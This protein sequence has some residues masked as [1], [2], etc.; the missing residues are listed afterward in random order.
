[1]FYA[2]DPSRD[3]RCRPGFIRPFLLACSTRNP[4]FAGNAVVCLQRLIIGKGLPEDSL[5]DV[6]EALRECST[7]ALDI[8]LKV[9][10][11]LPSLLQNYATSF[12]GPLLIAAFQ[13]CFLL[14][15]NKAA[16]V[17]NTAAATLQQLVSS[18]FE[19]AASAQ[20][21][22]SGAV[23]AAEVSIGNDTVSIQGIVLDAYRILDDLSL[24]TEGHKPKHIQG[25]FI[26]QNFG[27]ELIESC[28]ASHTDFLSAR[29]DQIHTLRIRLMP[30][31]IKLISEKTPFSTTVR[32]MR[33]LRLILTKLLVP[34]A[35]EC[36]VALSLLNHMLDG[37]ASPPW[38]RAMCLE[39]FR[40]LHADPALLRDI[41]AHFD[42]TEEK[43]NIVRDHLSGLVRLA[44]EKPAIIGL[45]SQSSIPLMAMDDS[46]EQAA[47]QAGG[48][49][50]SIGAAVGTIDLN[51]SGISN[52]WSIIKTPCIE[53]LDKS[54]EPALPA[55]YIYYLAL[56]C[57]NMFEE[58]LARFL[59]PF[60]VPVEKKQKRRQTKSDKE[61]TANSTE[62]GIG[63]EEE[64]A[65]L[66]SARSRKIPV[67][68]LSLTNHTEYNQISTSAHMVDQCWP[69]LLAASSTYLNA[70]M[71][72][73]NYHALV[74]S[75]Q[76]FTQVA[77]LVGLSTPRDAFL[78]AFGKHALPTNTL[79]A[80]KS[81][82][83]PKLNGQEVSDTEGVINR[84]QDSGP[85]PGAHSTKQWQ[86]I[87]STMPVLNSRHLLCLRAL[88]NLGIALGPVLDKSWT[89]IFE[90]LQQADLLLSA[91]GSAQRKQRPDW[92]RDS[93]RPTGE[94]PDDAE[95]LGL[96]IAAAET[97]AS[98]LFEASGELGREPFLGF[99]DCLCK[100]LQ[101]H[102]PLDQQQPS[103][104]LS[105]KSGYKKH[106]K[107]RSVSSTSIGSSTNSHEVAFVLDKISDVIRTNVLR[108]AQVETNHS[109][110]DLLVMNLMGVLG[111]SGAPSNIRIAAA[112]TFNEMLVLVAV[113]ETT[114]H[115][116]TLEDI[117]A[118][119]LS[120]L[121]CE[122]NVLNMESVQSS[123]TSQHCEFEIHRLALDA[124]RTILEH[125][126]DTLVQG[127][128]D[129]FSIV[130]STFEKDANAGDDSPACATFRARSISS[131][132]VRSSF[133][134]LQL[135][136]SDFLSS[137]PRSSMPQLL[138]TLYYFSSQES[139]LNISLT[140]ATFFRT[141]SDYL[142]RETEAIALENIS[143][144]DVRRQAFD[145]SS[146][147]SPANSLTPL[148]WL[149]LLSQ[150]ARLT[151]DSRLEVRHSAL[152]TLFRI[153]DANVDRLALRSLPA[154]LE[155]VARPIFIA[156][157]DQYIN[158]KSQTSSVNA[159]SSVET[160]NDTAVIA[161][162]GFSRLF[163]Q[164]FDTFKTYDKMSQMFLD[165]LDHFQVCLQ[166][167]V[168]SISKAVFG[169]ISKMLAEMEDQPRTKSL[170]IGKVWQI[171]TRNNPT[172]YVSTTEK[173][174]NNNDSLLAYMY[175]LGQLLRLS[176]QTLCLEQI[177]TTL[178]QLH[179]SITQATPSLHNTDVNSMTPV[180]KAVLEGLK[181]VP[182][183]VQG[184][185][186]L[187]VDTLNTF[188][189]MAYKQDVHETTPQQS[190]V[191]LS[192]ASM[193]MLQSAVTNLSSVDK[194][195]DTALVT[196]ALSSLCVPLDLKYGWQRDGKDPPP[197]KQATITAVS[198]LQ[199][200]VPIV[201]KPDQTSLPFWATIVRIL[202]GI[203]AANCD[204]CI[205]Q[206]R[207][208]EDEVFD[209]DSCSKVLALI[210]PTLG[211]ADIPDSIRLQFSE[212]LFQN[213]L[214]HEPNPDDLAWPGEDLLDGLK[215]D[216]FGSV[217]AL[218]PS[219]RSKMSYVLL[220][221]LFDLVAVHDGSVERINLAKAAGP[222]LILRIGLTLKTYILDQPLRGR[223][224][225]PR[226]QK[227]EMLYILKKM[228]SLNSVPEAIPAASGLT[229][230]RK[231]HL[232]RLYPLILKVLKVAGRDEAM[233]N[234]A[235]SVLEA[236]GEDFEQ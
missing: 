119:S 64:S 52:R 4:K 32:S 111:S 147:T 16:V 182:L 191:A 93:M 14:Y 206:S 128:D 126:G 40:G 215:R 21:A 123:R 82:P 216:H 207:I 115:P 187:V 167:Q 139:D 151:K 28:L 184:A 168:L 44:A 163:S 85:T 88:L 155:A 201:N 211:S 228:I 185:D 55:T 84:S 41:Y 71:D 210:V 102:P 236:V 138:D 99:L 144:K 137:V 87:E 6:L 112:N 57:L 72:S 114:D 179:A 202:G 9:L 142:L 86:S 183:T 63:P 129:V 135:I 157:E 165:L 213:S 143:S 125:C 230:R 100:L 150:L 229:S 5:G 180:Q 124:L 98:K 190:Y 136:C 195:N 36:E 33:V 80:F 117:R 188:V 224:P 235:R 169:G 127:W 2:S 145:I 113:S 110:W 121:M 58:G 132:S 12:T 106:Q 160:W 50:G 134:S 232:K 29:P 222:Y 92:R 81:T 90:T 3:L 23:H 26:A 53:Q 158:S 176:G 79:K 170:P 203:V 43:R 47:L 24:L 161:I 67:N 95:E 22:T 68:P 198:I 42:E 116:G 225:Q 217:K 48:L 20:D 131:T 60:C 27:L 186:I 109:G 197:W 7:L 130:L 89:I 173:I 133:G 97:A 234:A 39:M 105:P 101:D 91:T 46:S 38:K 76:K 214:I 218:T 75:F 219:Q 10:Q 30:L 66:Q 199:T 164:W 31:L 200:S 221:E 162:D 78:T 54:E 25:A 59:L 226:S 152:R 108:L 189:T 107:L 177:R 62:G 45:G 140:T 61:P 120:T 73:E 192:K 56:T 159:L 148:L 154:L 8:Q 233:T 69:A 34:L 220:D 205:N 17:S 94:D 156:N 181:M 19:K 223:M 172:L 96:E 122:I 77:G 194:A 175:C 11:A 18:T 174:S 178:E 212:S 153:L 74:R 65:K 146:L 70:T 208:P 231:K 166:R 171:W 35:S 15:G 103:N 204:V 141:T 149:T 83:A 193:T 37:E 51:T 13:V 118:R 1:M 49:V 196:A 104:T 209:M 227:N